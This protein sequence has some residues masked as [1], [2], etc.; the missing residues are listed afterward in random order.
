MYICEAELTH[1]ADCLLP[2]WV[3][4]EGS[5]YCGR[6]LLLQP[7]EVGDL[8]KFSGWQRIGSLRPLLQVWKEGYEPIKNFCKLSLI[9]LV[10]V[11]V[12]VYF[13]FSHGISFL[14]N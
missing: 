11:S 3:L 12:F 10:S 8:S 5:N 13:R 7:S 14:K 4:Y 2:R 1:L 9:S 6:Q